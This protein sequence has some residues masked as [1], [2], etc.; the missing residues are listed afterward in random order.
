MAVITQTIQPGERRNEVTEIQKAFISLGATIDGPELFTP[1][2]AGTLGP[3]T[4]AAIT[5]LKSPLRLWAAPRKWIDGMC[6][7][8]SV[9]WIGRVCMNRIRGRRT[10]V[11]LMLSRALTSVHR[12]L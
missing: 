9:H 6:P 11:S 5:A 4:Q 8:A 2:T 7:A 10:C 3:K 12:G 1:T